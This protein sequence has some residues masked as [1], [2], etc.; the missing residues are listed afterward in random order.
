MVEI[1]PGNPG[2][3]GTKHTAL[4]RFRH[5]AVAVRARAGEPLIVYSG[6]DRRGGHLYRFVGRGVVRDPADRGNSAFLA[7]GRLEAARFEPDGT[8]R[9]IPLEPSTRLDPF[10]PSR[11]KAAGLQ[12]PVL[13][14]NPDRNQAGGVPFDDDVAIGAYV[15]RFATLADLYPGSGLAQQGAILIDAHLAANA[16]GATPAAR[17]EDTDLD[18]LTGDLLIA[19]TSGSPDREGGA[20]PAVFGGPAGEP[21]WPHGFVMR[22]SDNLAD[23]RFQWLMAATGGEPWAGGL[24]FTNPDNLALDRLGNLWMVTD[25]HGASSATD[26]FGNNSCWV[27]PRHGPG[28]GEAFC[29]ATGPMEAELCGLALDAEERSL[30][31][32]VQHPGEIHGTRGAR[33]EEFQAFTLRDRSG[34]RFA[35]LRRVPKGSNWPAQAPGRP[36]RPGVVVFRR[37]NGGTL[38]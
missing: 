8:G 7:D 19:Y 9:W 28:A 34:A 13:L 10:L 1:D 12:A 24:G 23:G 33:M 26:V 37:R 20:D 11:F 30:F 6:C 2:D 31:L 18:P 32:A 15:E 14:P 35:Q 17:P 5:E 4:G 38:L 21:A 25:R 16:V 27:L 22:L 3:P 29:F 36:P